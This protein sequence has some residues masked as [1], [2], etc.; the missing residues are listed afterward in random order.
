[1][2][3]GARLSRRTFLTSSAAAASAIALTLSNTPSPASATLLTKSQASAEALAARDALGALALLVAEERFGEVRAA[4]RAGALSQIRAAC[5]SLAES[6]TGADDGYK[7]LIRGVEDLDSLTLR[8]ARGDMKAGR[9]VLYTYDKLIV[10]FD[11]F[12]DSI[13]G[14]KV[15][16]E[17]I[18]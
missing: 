5:R 1:M 16:V 7:L 11:D 12:L 9:K 8:A 13:T 10:V 14:L 4:L 2:S 17:L 6:Q 15:K 18:K 3:A